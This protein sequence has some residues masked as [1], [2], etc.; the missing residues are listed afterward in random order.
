MK[1]IEVIREA[2]M[3]MHRRATGD[4]RSVYMSIPA[5]PERDADLI[6]SAAIDELGQLRAERPYL[7]VLKEFSIWAAS[8]ENDADD[9]EQK[10]ARE[11]YSK[12]QV[13]LT[14]LELLR[15]YPS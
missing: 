13:A 1:T 10:L 14:A 5:D 4:D 3:K 12:C 11:W 2:M 7:E 9:V 15:R 6:L 8:P